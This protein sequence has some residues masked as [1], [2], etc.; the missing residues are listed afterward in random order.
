VGDGGSVG[1]GSV[2]VGGIGLGGSV[3]ALFSF[4]LTVAVM[5]FWFRLGILHAPR[6]MTKIKSKVRSFVIILSPHPAFG[7][8]QTLIIPQLRDFAKS[9]KQEYVRRYIP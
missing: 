6:N 7:I 1:G 9:G 8:V 4:S 5:G 2:S 3:G